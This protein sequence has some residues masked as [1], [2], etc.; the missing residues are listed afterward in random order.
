M[1]RRIALGNER[2]RKADPRRSAARWVV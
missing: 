2:S 1:E